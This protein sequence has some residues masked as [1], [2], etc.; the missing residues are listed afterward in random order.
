MN[1]NKNRRSDEKR[2]LQNIRR[3]PLVVTSCLTGHQKRYRRRKRTGKAK[4]HKTGLQEN[5]DRRNRNR[6][7]C[8]YHDQIRRCQKNHK[9]TLQSGRHGNPQILFIVIGHYEKILSLKL[10]IRMKYIDILLYLFSN[11]KRS[12]RYFSKLA[13][14]YKKNYNISCL[15][16]F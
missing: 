5:T 7:E 10:K 14:I 11:I 12:K 15:T 6:A 13:L 3:L 2:F 8:P 1:T 9:K 16:A 4:N